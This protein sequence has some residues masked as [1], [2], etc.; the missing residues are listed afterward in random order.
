MRYLAK[1]WKKTEGHRNHQAKNNSST[2]MPNRSEYHW[3]SLDKLCP[4]T[5][6]TDFTFSHYQNLRIKLWNGKQMVWTCT[7]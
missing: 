3:V 6:T 1:L 5:L 7:F 4:E 2:D